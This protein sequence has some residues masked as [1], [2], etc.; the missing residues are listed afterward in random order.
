M[1]CGRPKH[2]GP[3]FIYMLLVNRY[4][5]I[6]ADETPYECSLKGVGIITERGFRGSRFKRDNASSLPALGDV[7]HGP[8]IIAPKILAVE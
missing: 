2:N 1:N 7:L 4:R 5:R 8:H 3:A 6:T